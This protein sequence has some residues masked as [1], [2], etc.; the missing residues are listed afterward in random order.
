MN[1]LLKKLMA[2][3][4]APAGDDG[5]DTGG[6]DTAVVDDPGQAGKEDRGDDFTPTN[7][8]DDPQAGAGGDGG[9]N[10]GDGGATAAAAEPADDSHGE[11]ARRGHGIP[12]S[13]FDEVNERKKAVEAENER[14]RRELEEARNAKPAPAPAAASAPAATPAAEP[15]K[16]DADAK[17][18]EYVAALMEGDTGKAAK[19]RREINAHLVAQ[20]SEHAEA[21]VTSREAAKLLAAE[22]EATMKAHSWLDTPEG[23]E[24]LE[25]IVAARDH[26]IAKGVPAHQALRDAVTKIAPKFA[27]PAGDP[28]AGDLQDSAAATDTRTANA[29]KRGAADSQAQPPVVQAGIGNRATAARVNVAE[30]DDEQFANLPEAEK[31]RLR[32]D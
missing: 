31:K 12:K 9:G 32:G 15:A 29:L 10:G 24:A 16:F 19:I 3:F 25:L 1:P 11:G 30:L 18:E 17:E 27:P 28:P 13:R 22:V 14:L 23:A 4:Q 2:R 6:T 26:A 20:A 7:D 21:K 8:A 5:A